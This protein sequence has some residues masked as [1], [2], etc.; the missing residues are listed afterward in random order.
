MTD[1]MRCLVTGA[2][3]FV[4]QHLV[5]ALIN[6]GYRPRAL[7]RDP[8]KNLTLPDNAEVV[9]GDVLQPASLRNAVDGMEVVFHCAAA[10]GN[11]FTKAEIYQ[12]NLEGVGNLLEAVKGTSCRVIFVSSINVLGTRNLVNVNEDE[13]CRYSNDPAADVKIDAEALVMDYHRKYGV[14]V[15]IIRPGFIYGPGDPHNLPKLITALQRG[16]FSYISSK[17]NIVPIVH[18][19]AVV[20]ALILAAK[21]SRSIG[22]TYH[23]LDEK[24]ITT[25]GFV[26]E[27]CKAANLPPP[28]KVLPFWIPSLACRVFAGLKA[29]G[30]WKK[31]APIAPNSLRFLGTSRTFDL[32]RAKEELGYHYDVPLAATLP[33]SIPQLPEQHGAQELRHAP[34]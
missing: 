22:R 11:H 17:E 19:D 15:T 1:I 33:A 24:R 18:V 16:K 28:T 2:S 4:G 23:I 12:V 31:P 3:G 32:S 14:P 10:V 8:N 30:I 34:A 7:V 29:V 21:N 25:Q 13:A 5:K 20:Q 26:S 6:Q 9:A 27:L